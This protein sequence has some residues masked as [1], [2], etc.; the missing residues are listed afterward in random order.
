MVLYEKITSP[1]HWQKN[2]NVKMCFLFNRSPNNPDKILPLK[3]V[4]FTPIP[5][6]YPATCLV[7]PKLVNA[8]I[9]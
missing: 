9:K 6:I 7:K 3:L 4:I 5:I 1:R 2:A 8:G